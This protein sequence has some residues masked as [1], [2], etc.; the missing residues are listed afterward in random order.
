MWYKI[1]ELRAITS[2]VTNVQS[3]K[4]YYRNRKNIIKLIS[5]IEKFSRSVYFYR[6]A[7]N[8]LVM[9]HRHLRKGSV[10]LDALQSDIEKRLAAL[11]HPFS[12]HIS[13]YENLFHECVAREGV[14][15]RARGAIHFHFGT[16]VVTFVAFLQPLSMSMSIRDEG[17]AP[18]LGKGKKIRPLSPARYKSSSPPC[19]ERRNGDTMMRSVM[20]YAYAKTS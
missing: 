20:H 9:I 16:R 14:G 18:W 1:H 10:S 8:A 7:R 4:N 13:S 17:E 6:T 2:I 5:R 12:D 19:A 3:I 15:S 11:L